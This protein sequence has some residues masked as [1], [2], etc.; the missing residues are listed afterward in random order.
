[1]PYF[2]HD[3]L[4]FHYRDRGT[5]VAFFFQHGLGGETEKVFTLLELPRGFRLLGLDCR[6]HGKTTP[7][8]PVE[9]LRF[10]VF[11]DDLVALMDRLQVDRAIVGG[12]S[13]G[14]GVALNS[15][16]RYPERILGLVL[17]R[18]AWLDQPNAANA[19]IFA[20][21][22]RLI[23]DLGPE[24]APEALRKTPS[25]A[26]IKKE[27]TD[28]AESLVA[29]ISDPR[30]VETVAKLESISQDS[31]SRDRAQ[32]RR[33]VIPTLVLAN[34]HDSIHPFEFGENM[35]RE[36]PGAEFHELPSKSADP[37]QYTSQLRRKLGEF[38]QARFPADPSLPTI[39]C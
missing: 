8:G 7:L 9:K 2:N 36:I 30:A 18:P 39:L 14:A 24:K 19:E 5:G 17:L 11:A 31:P 28:A 12:T 35:A 33:I 32:W 38:L 16:L 3:N 37:A 13:M 6:G 15:A 34:R 10:D 25:Y 21:I 29:L 20:L 22:A 26:R 1:M 4:E 23:R 27:C